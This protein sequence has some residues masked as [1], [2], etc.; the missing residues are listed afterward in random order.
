MQGWGLTAYGKALQ[1]TRVPD[2]RP[3][4]TATQ[5]LDVT[6]LT[7]LHSFRL[8]VDQRILVFKRIYNRFDHVKLV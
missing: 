4:V 3:F 6:H 1:Q 5:L 7:H 2:R 8:R